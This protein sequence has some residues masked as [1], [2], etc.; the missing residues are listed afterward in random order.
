MN[1]ER[2]IKL[3]DSGETEYVEFKNS[4][5][6]WEQVGQTVSGFSNSGGG[7]ILIGVQDSGKISG[8][9]IGKGTIEKLANRIKK[10]TDPQIYPEITM[11]EIDGKNI[12]LIKVEENDEKPV[13]FKKHAY[14]RMGKSTHRLNSSEIRKLAKN[15]GEKVYWDEQ[16]CEKAT[17]D[18]I[19]EEKVRKFL[20]TARSKR[21]LNIDPD[22]S[23]EETL[24]RLEVLKDGK[25]TNACV[26]LF[27]KKLQRFFRQAET[28]CAK[29]KGTKPIT[30]IDMKV[31]NRDIFAQ[32]TDS[33]NF[34]KEHIL[35]EAEIKGTERVE[36]WEYPIEAVRE[37][38]TNAICHRDFRIASS[39]QVRIFDDRL[40][41][42]GCGRLPEP[43]TVEDLKKKHRSILRNP[44]IGRCFFFAK[45]IEEWGT[46]T[47]RIVQKCVENGLPEPLFEEL[48]G[49]LVVTFRKYPVNEDIIQEL[50]NRQKKVI[51]YM[52]E[53][54]TI[55]SG[56]F[57]KLF[58]EVSRETLRKDLKDLTKRGII[59][60]EGA[61]R[62]TV[63]VFA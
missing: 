5:K 1:S 60:K 27:G 50:N 57:H 63:Y 42:W 22:I 19:D 31:F 30:F 43:L 21:D 56:E 33:L 40:E 39:V 41:V 23:M 4:L 29:F 54:K 36:R 34:V 51:E 20:K 55:T 12:I 46:G 17:L 28:R 2:L 14:K 8:V 35:M 38:I 10:N 26:L 24:A 62:G 6:L 16:V 32:R 15:S 58:P 52:K 7:T 25:P 47:N 59:K 13:F 45:Y 18:D 48:S 3:I 11:Q 61:K 37:A 9:D 53:N 44:S 49:S